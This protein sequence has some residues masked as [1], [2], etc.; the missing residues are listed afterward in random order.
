[1]PTPFNDVSAREMSD[2]RELLVHIQLLYLITRNL[3]IRIVTGY[4]EVNQ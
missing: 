1:M 4:N 2:L 3:P